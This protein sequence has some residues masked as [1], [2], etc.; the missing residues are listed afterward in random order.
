MPYREGT[1]K[2]AKRGGWGGRRVAANGTSKEKTE[3]RTGLE[4]W[5]SKLQQASK[6][7]LFRHLRSLTV[8]SIQG[9][10]ATASN[11]LHGALTWASASFA[12]F[13]LTDTVWYN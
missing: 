2:Q 10:S 6:H 11:R 4:V 1:S 8:L 7:C 9:A 3:L 5:G 13:R 12:N